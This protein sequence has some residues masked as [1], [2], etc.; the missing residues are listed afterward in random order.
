MRAPIRRK[1]CRWLVVVLL[2][3]GNYA[4]AQGQESNSNESPKI[5]SVVVNVLGESRIGV[6][7]SKRLVLNYSDSKYTLTYSCPPRHVGQMQVP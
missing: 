6:Q 4:Q 3:A 7:Y 2:L 5:E 1:S